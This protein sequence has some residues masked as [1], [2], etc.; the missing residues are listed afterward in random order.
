LLDAVIAESSGNALF[1]REALRVARGSRYA[2]AISECLPTAGSY[3]VEIDFNQDDT[4][5]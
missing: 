5:E 1:D 2:P 4:N 3:I